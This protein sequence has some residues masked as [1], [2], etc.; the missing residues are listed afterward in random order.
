MTFRTQLVPRKER[1]PMRQRSLG[2]PEPEVEPMV[3][4]EESTQKELVVEMAKAIVA[5]AQSATK[6]KEVDDEL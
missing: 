1:Q 6:R 2:Y 5:V 3:V 4:I